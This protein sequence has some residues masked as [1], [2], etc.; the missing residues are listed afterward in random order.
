MTT[1]SPPPLEKQPPVSKKADISVQCNT[2]VMELMEDLNSELGGDDTRMSVSIQV[3]H[4]VAQSGTSTRRQIRISK[5]GL[6]SGLK[7]TSVSPDIEALERE[8]ASNNQI[9][10]SLG[11]NPLLGSELGRMMR[12][13]NESEDGS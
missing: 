5:Q 6:G 1:T 8:I 11:V 9:I 12:E 10:G 3:T 7:A 13:E 4:S 2:Q